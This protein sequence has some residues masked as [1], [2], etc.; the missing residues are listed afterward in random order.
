MTQAAQTTNWVV[1]LINVAIE[2]LIKERYELPAYSTLE[3]LAA[4]VRM[5]VHEDI[6][7]RIDQRV[8]DE[9]RAK[10]KQLLTPTKRR[11][12][13]TTAWTRLKELP[14][15]ATLGHLRALEDHLD[16][17]LSWG[18][19]EPPLHGI[20]PAKLKDFAA[21]ARGLSATE[22]HD[23]SPKKRQADGDYRR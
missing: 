13:R 16:W 7:S 2:V 20:A 9:L 12:D 18:A 23:F 5:A 11:G 6:F 8:G 22:M 21:E 1:D 3:R 4:N 19:V 10:I 15:R 14:R 17:L